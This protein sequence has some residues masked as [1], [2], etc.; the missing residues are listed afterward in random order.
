MSV[1][2]VR[3]SALLPYPDHAIFDLIERIED[4]PSFLPWCS[5]AQVD[6]SAEP[7][8]RATLQISFKGLRQ[9]FTTRNV[10]TRPSDISMTLLDGP[11]TRL[12]GGWHIEALNAE[13][14]KV[15]FS[16]DYE[17]RSGLLGRALSPIFGQIAGTFVD[18]FVREAD[19]RHG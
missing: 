5:G 13:A 16:L 18:A 3:K 15:S 14:C 2:S 9:Q 7:E 10:H 1:N 4:Y 8:I 19:R 17:M 6:R 12:D 11:F